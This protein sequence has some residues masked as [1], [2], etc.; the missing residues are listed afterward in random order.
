[1]GFKCECQI[2]R[3]IVFEYT[4][5]VTEGID[6][7]GGVFYFYMVTITTEIINHDVWIKQTISFSVGTLITHIIGM[8]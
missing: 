5:Y 4:V 7:D 3:N 6:F 2:R 8:S 1:M